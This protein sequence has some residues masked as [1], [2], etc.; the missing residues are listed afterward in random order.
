M[1]VLLACFINAGYVPM[2]IW[3]YPDGFVLN[4]TLLHFTS[5]IASSIGR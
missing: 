1:N 2:V 5:T 4:I 3:E